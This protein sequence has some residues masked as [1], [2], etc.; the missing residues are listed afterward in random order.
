MFGGNS[1]AG[2]YGLGL[3]GR[4]QVR[5]G[6][7]TRLN[8]SFGS[9]TVASVSDKAGFPNGYR[10]PGWWVPPMKS[11]SLAS[12]AEIEGDGDMA[13]AGAMGKNA[14]A[15]LS[16]VGDLAGVAQLII[17][18]VAA[19]TGSGT[20]DNAA[21]LAYLQLAA[22]LAGSGDMDG[23]IGAIAW[24]EANV[25]G[26]GDLAAIIYALG[27]LAADISSS[28]A[29]LDTSNVAAAVWGALA[30]SNNDVGTMGEKLNDAGSASNPWTEVIESGYTAAEI[31]RL[32]AAVAQGDATGMTTSP[33]FKS[34]D[35]TK[36]RVTGTVSGGNR[37]V[38]TRDAT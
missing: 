31:L 14:Q 21:L 8:Q 35:G 13:G 37:T 23:A 3:T 24:A 4:R 27:T 18:M 9:H 12:Y 32:L 19:L 34:I 10:H 5:Q 2:L 17:S 22:D 25:A 1:V 33:V 38:S 16:G 29:V 20:I 30:A 11:G 36:D 26:D 6:N 7:G 28:G 15:D